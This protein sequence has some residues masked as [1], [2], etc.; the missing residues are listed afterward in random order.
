MLVLCL[1]FGMILRTK[2]KTSNLKNVLTYEKAK[3]MF[4]KDSLYYLSPEN[5]DDAKVLGKEVV[6]YG[7]VISVRDHKA[8]TGNKMFFF[9]MVRKY[10][11][12]PMT[13][14][15]FE[16]NYDGDFSDAKSYEGKT[17]FVSGIVE[18]KPEYKEEGVPLKPSISVKSKNQIRIVE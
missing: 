2:N 15:I 18:L 4:G 5:L 7:K 11:D 12:N 3:E 17:I 16:N 6:T 13:I 10:P 8:S 9:N 1:I 14:M